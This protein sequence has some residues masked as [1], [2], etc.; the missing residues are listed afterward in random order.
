MA[1]SFGFIS[2]RTGSTIEARNRNE[3][4][5]TMM[6]T[7]LFRHRTPSYVLLQERCA[8]AVTAYVSCSQPTRGCHMG[9]E[10]WSWRFMSRAS[11]TSQHHDSWLT[12]TDFIMFILNSQSL[13]V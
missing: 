4:K 9:K 7:V 12:T 8:T 3:A 10:V 2:Q 11:G 5:Q 1:R 6:I 13:K